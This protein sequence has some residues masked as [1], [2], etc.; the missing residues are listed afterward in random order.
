MGEVYRAYDERLS[1]WVAVKQVRPDKQGGSQARARLLR[2]A[3]AAAGLA[4]PA[5][6]QIFDILDLEEGCWIVMEFIEGES[7]AE[8]LSRQLLSV[9]E[10]LEMA[11]S[12]LDGLAYAHGKGF[13]HRDLKT[14]NVMLSIDG[15]ARILDFG[16]AKDTS[17]AES[18]L[19]LEG[20]VLG[21]CRAMSPEQAMGMELDAKSDLFSFGVLIYEALTGI[22][23]FKTD[24]TIGTLNRICS[25]RQESLADRDPEIPRKLSRLVDHLLE[26]PSADRPTSK[27]AKAKLKSCI[28]DNQ[29]AS[30]ESERAESLF[31]QETFEDSPETRSWR[32]LLQSRPLKLASA[33][34]LALLLAAGAWWASQDRSGQGSMAVGESSIN[35]AHGTYREGMKLLARFDKEGYLDRAIQIFRQMVGDYPEL[36]TSHAG[37]AR[38]LLIKA[39]RD[40]DDAMKDEALQIALKGVEVN[41][42]IAAAQVSLGLAYLEVDS[43]KSL[44]AFE[45]AL[46]LDP[47]SAD[48]YRGLGKLYSLQERPEAAEEAF[49]RAIEIRPGDRELHD[50]LGMLLFGQSRFEE[51]A[52]A[53]RESIEA[54]PN[55]IFGYSNLAGALFMQEKYA[56]AAQCLQIALEIQPSSDLY[57]NLGTMLFFQGLYQESIEPFRK[58]VE[59]GVG[60]RSYVEWTN[61]GDAYRWSPGFQVEAKD[62]YTQCISLIDQ[63]LARQKAQNTALRS[64]RMLCLARRGDWPEALSVAESLEAQGHLQPTVEIFLAMA[65]EQCGDR[66]KALVALRRALESGYPLAAV[67]RERELD[68]LRADPGFESL[69]QS[70]HLR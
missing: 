55:N 25:Y 9:P 63:R 43:E 66:E 5:I 41:P 29:V 28:Q 58:A 22:S 4:H 23:P 1:R 2:E 38:A 53:F 37:L 47:T 57:T 69:V 64:A 6:V 15:R 8:R 19:T 21:T 51:A 14:E 16:L 26:K 39:S 60:K 3:R 56:E 65:Y 10:V 32:G 44:E 35:D 36:A 61:L 30:E 46:R 17:E 24:S 68:R 12:V 34:F 62:A 18:S 59:E 13:L 40:R 42:F 20:T 49:R 54:Q 70:L 7:L 45:T 67:T 11:S 31:Q 52:T 27:E 50:Q 48:G 33:G